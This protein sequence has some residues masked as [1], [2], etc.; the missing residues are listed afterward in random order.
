[1]LYCICSIIFES[2]L[3]V[4]FETEEPTMEQ[5]NNGERDS[6]V[7]PGEGTTTSSNNSAAEKSSLNPL[8]AQLNFEGHFLFGMFRSYC[9]VLLPYA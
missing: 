4:L 8:L 2:F 3:R 9:E 6:F 7:N 5:S 1:M